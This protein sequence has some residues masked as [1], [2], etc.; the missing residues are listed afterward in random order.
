MKLYYFS[1]SMTDTGLC[2]EFTALAHS[3]QEAWKLFK[4]KMNNQ[5]GEYDERLDHWD[6][7]EFSVTK[8][9]VIPHYNYG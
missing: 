4:D 8:P 6:V 1:N 9:L 7:K 5:L 3:K 2:A